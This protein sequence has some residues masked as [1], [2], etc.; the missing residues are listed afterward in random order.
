M[1]IKEAKEQIKNAITAYLIKD[2]FGDYKISIEHQRPVFLLGAPGIGKTYHG[3]DRTGNR[4]QPD[5]ILDGSP[6]KRICNG[7]SQHRYQKLYR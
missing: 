1:N 5:L 7:T 2:E 4:T 3:A 6:D